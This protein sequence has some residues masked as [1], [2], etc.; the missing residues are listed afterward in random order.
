MILAGD[1]GGTKINLA[2]YGAEGDK[3]VQKLVMSYPSQQFTTLND[4]L[5][6]LRKDHPAKIS[7]AAFGIAGPIVDGRSR[8]TNLKWLIDGREVAAELQLPQVGLINDLEATAYGT[9]RLEQRDI[10]VLKP[11]T[12]QPRRTIAVVAAGTGL[13]EGALVWD[14]RRYRAIPSEGGHTDFGPRNELEVELFR[15]LLARFGRVSYERIV[16]GPGMV[17][18]YQFFRSRASS[19]E[20]TWLQ[21]Q[22]AGGDPP[23]A[24]SQAGMEGKDDVCV[25]SLE[26]FVT[27]YGAEVGN[28][29]LKFLSTGGVYIGG[30]IAPKILSRLQGGDFIESFVGK[31]RY[32]S[33]L[34]Q[35]PVSVILNDKTALIG[36]AHYALMMN[37]LR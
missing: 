25:Q 16:S 9:L 10:L 34:E 13:G 6:V 24:I 17:N 18:L 35:M 22:M 20:P 37:D 26:M 2:Y 1:I 23:A 14:G 15:F 30:G 27:I 21:E 32:R 11:G 33:L 5:R 8:L 28:T 3:L 29:A 7:S 31:G 12:A 4:V 19:P 36:A